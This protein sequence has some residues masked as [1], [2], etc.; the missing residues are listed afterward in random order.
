MPKKWFEEIGS[1]LAAKASALTKPS[2][3][4]PLS[5]A[6]LNLTAFG[7]FVYQPTYV[8]MKI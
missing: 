6:C 7:N 5:F 1:S 2:F 3:Y 4:A 8:L